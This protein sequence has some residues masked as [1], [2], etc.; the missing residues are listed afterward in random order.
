MLVRPGSDQYPSRD[1]LCFLCSQRFD[2]TGI[3]VMWAG[4]GHFIYLHGER[5]ATSFVLRL[6]RDALEVEH[7]QRST[8]APV[9]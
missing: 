7:A 9:G 8:E 5:C 3:V 1:Q 4:P 2:R 6:S